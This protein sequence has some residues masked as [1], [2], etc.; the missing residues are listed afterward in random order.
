MITFLNPLQ[1]TT[2]G[3]LLL[4]GNTVHVIWCLCNAAHVSIGETRQKAAVILPS[5]QRVLSGKPHDNNTSPY[6]WNPFISAVFSKCT[7]CTLVLVYILLNILELTPWKV[8]DDLGQNE[9]SISKPITKAKSSP[10][11][12]GEL[13]TMEMDSWFFNIKW[14]KKYYRLLKCE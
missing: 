7:L 1:I 14:F 9:V 3:S 6:G 11:R 10:F 4:H 5:F 13:Y 2:V 12:I 8:P